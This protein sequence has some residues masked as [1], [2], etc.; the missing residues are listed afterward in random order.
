MDAAMMH[1]KQI[2]A[3]TL[4]IFLVLPLDTRAQDAGT[5]TFATGTVS[6]ERAPPVSLAKGD[7]VLVADTVATAER[8]R[9][10]LMMVDNA[11]ISIR[12]NSRLR[13]EEYFYADAS[14]EGGQAAVSSAQN[15][16]I[17]SLLKG[18]FRTITGAIGS[19]DP[20]DYEVRTPVGV[21]GIRGTDYSA[22]FCN[23]DC[24]WAP[25][26]SAGQPIEAG[27]YLG[28]TAGVIFFRNENGDFELRAGR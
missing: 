1:R 4:T 15:S 2:I 18:G 7:A 17:T 11:K 24:D 25:G 23:G 3:A 8:S 21:L 20:D 19:E 27:L 28:V 14:D 16:S 6:A 5:V 9:A 13:I 12:P 26:V 22:V 10:Q